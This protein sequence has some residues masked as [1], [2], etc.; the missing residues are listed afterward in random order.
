MDTRNPI[1]SPDTPIS[2]HG[3][4]RQRFLRARNP[5]ARHNA[6]HR[7]HAQAGSLLGRDL[8]IPTSEPRASAE[9]QI[10]SIIAESTSRVNRRSVLIAVLTGGLSKRVARRSVLSKP[11]A[12]G[13]A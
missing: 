7:F 4:H 2:S 6:E 10:F 12:S 9:A 11:A 3:R 8:C 13:R 1:A 5:A